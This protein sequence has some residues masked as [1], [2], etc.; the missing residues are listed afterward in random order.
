MKTVLLIVV[1]TGCLL[2]SGCGIV[3]VLG[4]ATPSEKKVPAEFPLKKYAKGNVLVF[5]DRTRTS[6]V[7]FGFHSELERALNAYME[8][9]VRVSKKYM[10]PSEILEQLK[11]QRSDFDRLSPVEI[12]SKLGASV[13]LYVLIEDYSLYQLRNRNYYTG[14]VMTRSIV[15]D[16]ATG[17]VLWPGG[18]SGRVIRAKVEVETKGTGEVVNR[19]TNTVAHCITRYFY[20][21]SQA[22]FRTIDEVEQ[23]NTDW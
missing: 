13:V 19:L 1:T 14:S 11:Q 23:I 7:T 5:V 6:N 22:R 4:D 9:K 3:S 16:V 12:G 18:D 2:C 20:N 21:C 8:K 10:I 15:F 17:K